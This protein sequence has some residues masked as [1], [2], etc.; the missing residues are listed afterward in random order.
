[1]RRI[2][3]NTLTKLGCQTFLEAG[4]GREDLGCLGASQ[5]DLVITDCNMP[6]TRRE[7]SSLRVGPRRQRSATVQEATRG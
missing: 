1:M 3:I 6:E 7:K 5:I 2:I 4:N